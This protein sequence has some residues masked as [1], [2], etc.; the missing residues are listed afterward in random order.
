MHKS[1]ACV[2]YLLVERMRIILNYEK[3]FNKTIIWIFANVL[4]CLQ[5]ISWHQCPGFM[6]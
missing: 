3:F 1:L 2:L 6:G 4:S 5:N